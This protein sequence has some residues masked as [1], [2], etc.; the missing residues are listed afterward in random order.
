MAAAGGSAAAAA[1]AV[2]YLGVSE[3]VSVARPTPTDEKRAAEMT[4]FLEQNN[5]F[6]SRADKQHREAVLAELGRLLSAWVK[7]VSLA[8]D[9]PLADPA[10]QRAH[11]FSFGSY[12][13]GVNARDADIDTVCIVP[14]H[15]DAFRD[16]FG[17]S[18]DGS[19]E[20]PET[21][22]KW[23][24]DERLEC[25]LQETLERHPMCENLV[26][27]SGAFTPILTFD[28]NGVEIDVACGVVAH[29]TL[30]EVRR[31][32]APAGPP[33]V[34]PERA[35]LWQR[36]THIDD[37]YLMGASE[38]TVRSLNGTRVADAILQLV[39][40]HGPFK[41]AL[42]LIKMWCK[43]RGLYSNKLGY[44][45]GVQ[46]AILT[47]RICQLYP[48]A[49]ANTIVA[50]F[51]KV[52]GI[53]STVAGK[54]GPTDPIRLNKEGQEK[55]TVP[56]QGTEWEVLD[57]SIWEPPLQEQT[58]YG[59][60]SRR[61]EELLPI[62]TPAY[63]SMNSTFNMNNSTKRILLQELERGQKITEQIDAST[64]SSMGGWSELVEPT[65]FFSAR[66][67]TFV[68]VD[69]VAGTEENH[70]SWVGLSESQLR[71]FVDSLEGGPGRKSQ[72]LAHVYP[73]GFDW[74]SVWQEGTGWPEH[75][76]NAPS[77][78]F[79]HS[80]FIGVELKPN[81]VPNEKVELRFQMDKFKA[82]LIKKATD[83]KFYTDDMSV[84]M[85][86]VKK[87]VRANRCCCS[88]VN[89]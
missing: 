9:P 60:P 78:R 82:H 88:P 2:R 35:R 5:R 66:Y 70:R 65:D 34:P 13:L 81:A 80:F 24:A 72:F 62:L 11:L 46:L 43:N 14:S 71:T 4:T 57:R 73:K 69:F 54:W 64:A 63:P 28:F 77:N 53:W 48:C 16:F 56:G 55:K 21:G 23:R 42:R 22:N 19:E 10:S 83:G 25:I 74:S 17:L 12:R 58:T 38:N 89:K 68:R 20:P 44:L 15:I 8:L 87:K 51:F 67:K 84:D 3:P 36:M 85:S 31:R 33:S 37:K 50:K 47:A 40:Q 39:P 29:K 59:K 76:Q 26:A 49:A 75:I 61:R 6:E 1:A 32:A 45:G 86:P 27:V 79:A 41:L 52:L 30:P 7:N 18:P